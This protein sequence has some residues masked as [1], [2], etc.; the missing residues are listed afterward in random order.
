MVNGNHDDLFKFIY[1]NSDLFHL[2]MITMKKTRHVKK[3]CP[4]W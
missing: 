1:G 4:L 2:T 3:I